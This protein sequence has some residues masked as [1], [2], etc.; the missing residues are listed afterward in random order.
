MLS[1]KKN[2][3]MIYDDKKNRIYTLTV[4]GNR[5]TIIQSLKK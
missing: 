2:L 1:K 4:K 3:A 5:Q